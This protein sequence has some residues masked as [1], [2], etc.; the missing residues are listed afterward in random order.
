MLV[1]SIWGHRVSTIATAQSLSEVQYVTGDVT[2]C[3]VDK[4]PIVGT[5]MLVFER[6][7][8]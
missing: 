7:C 3:I 4:I 5:H 8:R 6:S 2:V 1:E